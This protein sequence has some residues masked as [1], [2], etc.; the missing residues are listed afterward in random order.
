MTRNS[1]KMLFML[2]V[3]NFIF[4]QLITVSIEWGNYKIHF[5]GLENEKPEKFSAKN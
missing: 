2:E 3:E 5:S 4:K 1:K